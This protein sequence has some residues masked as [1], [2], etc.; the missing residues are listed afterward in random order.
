MM[1]NTGRM[2]SRRSKAMPRLL[3]ALGTFAAFPRFSCNF[4]GTP[5]S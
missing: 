2:R 4:S 5:E 3:S 1:A